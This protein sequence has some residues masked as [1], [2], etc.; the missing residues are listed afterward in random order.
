MAMPA[1]ARTPTAMATTDSNSEFGAGS[2]NVRP[3]KRMRIDVVR[4]KR[5]DVRT[6]LASPL[7]F[8]GLMGL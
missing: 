1:L 4:F 7:L 8:H 5:L 2:G 6:G 3:A